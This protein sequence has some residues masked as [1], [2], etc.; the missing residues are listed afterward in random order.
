MKT[1]ILMALMIIGITSACAQKSPRVQANGTIDKVEI[2]IDY[3]SPQVKGR[4]IYGVDELVDY[5]QVWRAGADKNTTISF[6]KNVVINGNELKA[7]KY[8]FFIIPNADGK[9]IAI[10][11]TKNDA[12]G[13]YSY[14]EAEDALRIEV[15][16]KDTKE[17]VESLMF[18]VTDDS[19]K[20]AWADK[21]FKM[22]VE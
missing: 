14:K 10:F 21:Y 18:K 4:T 2:A 11:N 12:W 5:G 19:I 9:W 13:S 1:K 20:F 15:E 8:G 22:S 3:S 7:G 16:A 6:S 17:T